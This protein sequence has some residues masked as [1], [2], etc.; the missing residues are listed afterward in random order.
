MADRHLLLPPNGPNI[1]IV[2]SRRSK[3][4]GVGSNLTR[5]VKWLMLLCLVID[6]TLAAEWSNVDTTDIHTNKQYWSCTHLFT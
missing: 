3:V 4:C 2:P 5:T 6:I 1:N